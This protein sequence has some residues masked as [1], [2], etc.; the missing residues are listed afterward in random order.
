M[1]ACMPWCIHQWRIC[2]VSPFPI[3]SSALVRLW[4]Y[5]SCS[6]SLPNAPLSRSYWRV[7]ISIRSYGIWKCQRMTKPELTKKQGKLPK[8]EAYTNT[9]TSLPWSRTFWISF[10]P[11][12]LFALSTIFYVL[13]SHYQLLIFHA[14]V[15]SA[16]CL[17]FGVFCPLTLCLHFITWPLVGLK[18]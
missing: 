4:V 11:W 1:F 7:S 3:S 6:W 14:W 9:S 16:S 10:C 15:S 18:S 2:F 5:S 12:L 8:V 13:A 17:L